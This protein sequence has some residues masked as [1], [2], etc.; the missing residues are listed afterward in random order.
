[1]ASYRPQNILRNTPLPRDQPSPY[2]GSGNTPLHPAGRQLHIGSGRVLTQERRHP[3]HETNPSHIRGLGSTPVP[4]PGHQLDIGSGRT[5]IYL[6]TPPYLETTPPLP[7][8]SGA[9]Q[10]HISSGWPPTPY[11]PQNILRKPPLARDRPRAHPHILIHYIARI[12]KS[13]YLSLTVYLASL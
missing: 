3:Y 7:T 11:T 12:S 1:L 5:P 4:P 9:P 6:S 2:Q 13:S 8:L 10:H